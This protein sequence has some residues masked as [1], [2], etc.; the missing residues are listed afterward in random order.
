MKDAMALTYKEQLQQP[1][2]FAMR[3]DVYKRAN[4]RCQ[5]CGKENVRLNAHHSYYLRGK[6]AWEYPIES[7]IALCDAC[8]SKAAHG[9]PEDA[10]VEAVAQK[11]AELEGYSSCVQ[12]DHEVAISVK[13]QYL[14][15]I[16]HHKCGGVVK[17][18]AK[19]FNPI[20]D[21]LVLQHFYDEVKD[22]VTFIA[23]PVFDGVS[24]FGISISR[25]DAGGDPNAIEK[26]IDFAKALK[27]ENYENYVKGIFYDTKQ[28][29]YNIEFDA[30]VVD[31]SPI[32]NRIFNFAYRT[33]DSFEWFDSIQGK[34][35]ILDN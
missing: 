23:K 5:L 1:A 22:E 34:T 7:L 35:K 14:A 15:Y 33:L 31:G 11:E 27:S 10:I 21:D 24:A 29:I 30:S 8:H 32:A 28:N 2:W 6:M 26:M 17:I 19:E 18:S 20:A 4:D 12:A 25:R 16:I 3:K 13:E 9:N